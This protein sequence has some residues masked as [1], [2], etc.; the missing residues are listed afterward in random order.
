MW[1]PESWVLESRIPLTIIVSGILD[2]LCCILDLL[3]SL[4]KT[5]IHYLESRIHCVESRIQDCLRSP[6]MGQK[7]AS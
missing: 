4:T 7:V 5:G 2:S 1:H 6:Y 3:D